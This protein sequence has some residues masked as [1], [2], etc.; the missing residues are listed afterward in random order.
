[1]EAFIELKNIDKRFGSVYALKNVSLTVRKGETIALVGE[2]G[3]GKSTLMKILTGA[4]QKDSGEI[5]MGGK[6]ANLNSTAA[7]K[8]YGI[9]QVYQQAEVWTDLSVAENIYLGEEGMADHGV[10]D[11]KAIKRGT[12]EILDQY[13]I[14][15]DVNK[16]LKDLSIASRQLVSIAKVL[17]RSPRAI[18]FDE[19]TAV[20]SD[21]EVT[22]L[23]NII[24]MLKKKGV[25]II[26]ISHRLEE[27][28]EL[29]DR[30]AVMRDGEMIAVLDNNN[31]TKD[32][33]IS[34]ML[35]RSIDAIF[36]KK[37]DTARTE[38][39]LECCDIS[40]KKVYDI[41]FQLYKGEILGIVGLVNSGRTELAKAIYGVDPLKNGKITVNGRQIRFRSPSD[42]TKCGMFL[43]PEDR[44]G[45]ALVTVRQIRENITLSN[46][47]SIS[48]R[49]ICN[50]TIER[51][52]VD[53]LMVS[54][55]IKASSM[56]AAVSSLS[57]GNQQKVVIAK[58]IAA[59]PDILIFDEPTQGIDIGAKAEIYDLLEKLRCQGK[60]II[61][62]SSEIEEIQSMCSRA[63]VMRN[64]RVAGEVSDDI[65][66][67]EKILNLMYRSDDYEQRK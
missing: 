3:A 67:T 1:M 61:F 66:D 34:Y 57:G 47:K 6:I 15:L 31:L 40:T 16:K 56:E 58:A 14:S 4:Y 11:W 51:D 46:L 43:A 18:I 65:G 64:G 20:L 23:F 9:A 27:I 49:G 53:R 35:G 60:A 28:F 52:M 36:P 62:I 8:R 17:R 38:I 10:V 63:L 44:K 39:A 48:R 54:L 32:A 41:S 21:N 45:E 24:K 13:N 19:P 22:I 30:V 59:E 26:Y 29:C 42:A 33:L 2:N 50:T 37:L 7:A 25:T 55:R 5:V 12:Q